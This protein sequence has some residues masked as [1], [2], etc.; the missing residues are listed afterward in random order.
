M[1]E[2]KLVFAQ[3]TGH[4]PLTTFGRCVAAMVGHKIRAF[5]VWISISVWHLRS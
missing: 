4:L 2:G 1:H 5:L 3:L